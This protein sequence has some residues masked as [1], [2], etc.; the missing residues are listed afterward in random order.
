MQVGCSNL[1]RTTHM[2]LY[3]FKC[4]GMYC[5]VV[6]VFSSSEGGFCR[7]QIQDWVAGPVQISP[8]G[9]TMFVLGAF[10][11]NRDVFNEN[12]INP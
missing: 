7:F 9:D 10:K 1:E 11:L 2:G 4:L 5:L 12:E 8:E 6:V 3:M